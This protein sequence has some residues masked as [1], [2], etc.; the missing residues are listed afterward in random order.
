MFKDLCD[1]TFITAVALSS[2]LTVLLLSKRF[3]YLEFARTN[4]VRSLVDT[5]RNP[6]I[7]H[8]L[9]KIKGQCNLDKIKEAYQLHLL[10]KREKNGKLSYPRLKLSLIT[11]WSQYAWVKNFE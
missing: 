7:L 11:C 4:T 1:I 6:G 9:V 3:K 10:D 8:F 5:S 2:K